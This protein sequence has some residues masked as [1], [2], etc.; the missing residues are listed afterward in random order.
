MSQMSFLPHNV[1]AL[2][3]NPV[4][5]SSFVLQTSTLCLNN[6][7]KALKETTANNYKAVLFYIE[8][9][10]EEETIFLDLDHKTEQPQ[11]SK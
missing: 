9:T 4:V 6:S 5:W 2:Q 3:E 10:A 1:K 8:Q 7:V 11:K